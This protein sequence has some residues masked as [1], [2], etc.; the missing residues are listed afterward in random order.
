MDFKAIEAVVLPSQLCKTYFHKSH[1]CGA[2]LRIFKANFRGFLSVTKQTDLICLYQ[3]AMQNELPLIP[4]LASLFWEF[5]IPQLANFPGILI[6][7]NHTQIPG[8]SRNTK[9]VCKISQARSKKRPLYSHKEINF[10][11]KS[12]NLEDWRTL[13]IYH[14]FFE[15][16]C[17][18]DEGISSLF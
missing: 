3:G 8:Y 11:G 13:C 16:F 18:R 12:S 5:W 4:Q 9:T 14:R 17:H 7:Q 10:L 1:N 6:D 2:F 15:A